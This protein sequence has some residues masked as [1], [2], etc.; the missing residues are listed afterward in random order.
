MADLPKSELEEA[1]TAK[2]LAY[3]RARQAGLE[4]YLA[5]RQAYNPTSK[6]TT[7]RSEG[8]K[9]ERHK[10]I[11]PILNPKV[12]EVPGIVTNP[13]A[14]EK[15][16]EI[17]ATREWVMQQLAHNALLAQA[18]GDFSASNKAL[19][20]MGKTNDIRLFEQQ[21]GEAERGDRH[22]SKA[23]PISSFDG[24]LAEVARM[25]AKAAPKDVVQH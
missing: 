1:L 19:E 25:G 23:R 17:C 15:L 10:K 2:Q 21:P 8:S 14:L 7:A 16:G 12:V 6:E 5:Y 24:L 22:D 3:V 11:A 9:L 20:L 13:E 4:P 18:K